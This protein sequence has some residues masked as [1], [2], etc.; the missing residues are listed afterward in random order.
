MQAAVA[1]Q[2]AASRHIRLLALSGP[3]SRLPRWHLGLLQQQN[4][5]V[6]AET[7]PVDPSYA[8]R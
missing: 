1:K 3:K 8:Q 5:R 2:F 6:K 4:R 7:D